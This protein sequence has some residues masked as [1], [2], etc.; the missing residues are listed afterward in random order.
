MFMKRL[1]LI[2]L[3]AKDVGKTALIRT[4]TDGKPRHCFPPTIGVDYCRVMCKSVH[5]LC[6]DTS[7]DEKFK[8][9]VEMFTKDCDV[10]L[11]AFDLTRPETID[12]A[13]EWYDKVN[14]MG[15]GNQ[16]SHFFIGMK[17]DMRYDD[18]DII[19]RI[20]QFPELTYLRVSTKSLDSTKQLWRSIEAATAH[21]QPKAVFDIIK[22][23]E[24]NRECCGIQ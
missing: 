17:S 7:G 22:T 8:N 20:D 13:F 14:V 18:R 9:V 1:R 4:M 19:K 2:C 12:Q 16:G 6:W 5:F 24:T 15:A 10:F 23:T 21:I 3:G 11:F